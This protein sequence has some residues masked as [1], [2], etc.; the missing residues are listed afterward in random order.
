[1]RT[2]SGMR[3]VYLYKPLPFS[4][5]NDKEKFQQAGQILLDYCTFNMIHLITIIMTNHTLIA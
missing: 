3:R 2:F 5:R 4:R 1:M